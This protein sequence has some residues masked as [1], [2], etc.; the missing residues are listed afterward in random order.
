MEKRGNTIEKP[1]LLRLAYWESLLALRSGD[2]RIALVVFSLLLFVAMILGVIRTQAR[3]NNARLAEQEN[4]L[5]KKIFRDVLKG[6][7][8]STE[9]TED[10]SSRKSRLTKQLRMSAK[11]PYLVSHANDLWNA[12]LLPSPLSALSVGAS[13]KAWPDLYPI[14]GFSLSKTLQRSEQTRPDATVYGPFDTTF[15]IMVITPLVIIGLTF[16]A[17]SHDRESALQSLI[18]AQTSSLGRLMAVRCLVR[19]ALLIGLVIGIVNGTLL[20]AFKDQFDWNVVLNLAVWNVSAS[21]Y[22]MIWA[23]FSLFINSFAKSSSANGAALLLLWVILVL[24]I[25]KFVSSAVQEAIQTLPESELV[26]REK[27]SF[28]HASENA[29]SLVKRFKLEHPNIEIRLDDEQQM[30]LARYLL[31][32]NEA[33]KLAPENVAAHYSAQSTRASYLNYCDWISPAISFRNQSDQCSGNSERAFIAFSAR[34]AEIH[35]QIGEVFLLPGIANTECTLEMIEAL[36]ALQESEIPKTPSFQNSIHSIGS[37]F[38]WLIILVSLGTRQFRTKFSSVQ[39]I[40][41][42]KN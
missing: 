20:I 4:R 42:S 1:G 12:S 27:S 14:Q 15:V 23:A 37:M 3:Q 36:P 21:L 33:G 2:V 7:I 17:S 8:D 38:I 6:T 24:L 26:D 32:H 30:T 5:V 29:D 25:P 39:N 28:D 35:A 13:S 9:T 11:S 19:A 31:A 18:V 40:G 34:V 10:K 22:M 41:L 16:N